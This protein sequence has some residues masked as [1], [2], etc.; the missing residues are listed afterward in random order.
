MLMFN[1]I[2]AKLV[3][4]ININKRKNRHDAGFFFIIGL[5][6]TLHSAVLSSPYSFQQYNFLITLL[7]RT[8]NFGLS[9]TKLTAHKTQI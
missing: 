6:T 8:A 2:G 5:F 7:N 1:S 9:L 3:A 4:L